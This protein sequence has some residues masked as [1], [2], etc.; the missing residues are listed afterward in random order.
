MFLGNANN[1]TMNKTFQYPP[2]YQL[3]SHS[4]NPSLVKRTFPIPPIQTFFEKWNPLP[5]SEEKLRY[6]D[7]IVSWEGVCAKRGHAGF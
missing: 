3:P 7:W 4:F 2:F 1:Q 6:G 5:V